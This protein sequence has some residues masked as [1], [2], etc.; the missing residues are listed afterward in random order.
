ME[1]AGHIERKRRGWGLRREAEDKGERGSILRRLCTSFSEA[2][3]RFRKTGA[4]APTRATFPEVAGA[5]G[6]HT[7]RAAGIWKGDGA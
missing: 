3:G 7:R 6:C 2:P 1:I 5:L 4:R